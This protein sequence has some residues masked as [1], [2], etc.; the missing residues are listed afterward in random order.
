MACPGCLV[1]VAGTDGLGVDSS[2]CPSAATKVVSYGFMFALGAT[3]A[4]LTVV[5]FHRDFGLQVKPGSFWTNPNRR[6][7]RR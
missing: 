5:V 2:A 3:A 7:R 6:R 1:A 4:V